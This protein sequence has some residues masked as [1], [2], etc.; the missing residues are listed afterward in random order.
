MENRENKYKDMKE[1]IFKYFIKERDDVDNIIKV[2]C[3]LSD[4]KDKKQFLKDLIE[5]CK[6]IKDDFFQNKEKK[7]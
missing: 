4:V 3:S 1:S 7:K 6:F 2:I 5:K